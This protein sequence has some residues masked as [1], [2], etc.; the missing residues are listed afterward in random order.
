MNSYLKLTRFA[1]EEPHNLELQLEVSNGIFSGALHIYLKRSD[2]EEIGSALLLF[3]RNSTD[4]YR[5]EV[6]SERLEDRWA[7]YFLLRAFTFGA[8]G[9]SAILFRLN[10]NRDLPFRG[11]SEFCIEA[12][13]AHINTL[14]RLL[15]EFGKLEHE[16]L[17]WSNAESGVF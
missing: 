15:L 3:P 7:Y 16:R 10:N 14:G 12:E 11:L 17:L 9:Q 4:V 1:Y 13:V 5:F 6:G 2:I 8:R